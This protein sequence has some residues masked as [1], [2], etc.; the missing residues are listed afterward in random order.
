VT[1]LEQWSGHM[2][3]AVRRQV[4]LGL[5]TALERIEGRVPSDPEVKAHAKTLIHSNGQV[6]YTWKGEQIVEI[7]PPMLSD[8]DLIYRVVRLTPEE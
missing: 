4:E 7:E 1:A 3:P 8:G 5:I 6:L 2:V